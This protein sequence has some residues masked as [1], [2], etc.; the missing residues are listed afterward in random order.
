MIN[1]CCGPDALQVLGAVYN[2]IDKFQCERLGE[3]YGED[4]AGSQVVLLTVSVDAGVLTGLT[5]AVSDASA[6][7]VVPQEVTLDADG[8]EGEGGA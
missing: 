3:D 4:E 1:G 8:Q 6:G 5:T 2:L 7:K